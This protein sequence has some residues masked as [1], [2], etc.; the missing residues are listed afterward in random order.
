MSP[1]QVAIAVLLTVSSPGTALAQDDMTNT[2]PVTAVTVPNVTEAAPTV[3]TVPAE[4]FL[5]KKE[6]LENLGAQNQE[7]AALRERVAS[8]ENRV[9]SL[10]E[11][12]YYRTGDI[13]VGIMFLNGSPNFMVEGDLQFLYASYVAGIGIE[14]GLRLRL[15]VWRI[16]IELLDLGAMVYTGD[17]YLSV[18]D[19]ART[20][21]LTAK[22]GVSVRIWKGLTVRGRVAW[23][24]PN[25]GVAVG[26]AGDAAQQSA[27]QLSLDPLSGGADRIADVYTRAALAPKVDIAVL[28]AF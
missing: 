27:D 19:V 22:A 4:S 3:E 15:E 5:T 8:L 1:F 14:G 2:A 9:N 21:D 17:K 16:T 12:V 28:W 6:F 13:G 7:V 10:E 26:L 24:M 25:P 18:Q 20:W 11:A 23:Y